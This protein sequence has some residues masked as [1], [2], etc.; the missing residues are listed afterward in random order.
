[1]FGMT[2]DEWSSTPGFLQ[3]FVSE[4]DQGSFSWNYWNRVQPLAFP[5]TFR[6]RGIRKDGSVFAA[7]TDM[8]PL[9]YGGH[10]IALHFVREV[11]A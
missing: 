2:V 7:E 3:Q 10:T 4:E 5:A 8:I 9:T 1:M 6:F 11:R